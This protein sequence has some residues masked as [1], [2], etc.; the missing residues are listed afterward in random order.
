MSGAEYG[1]QIDDPREISMADQRAISGELLSAVV[2]LI[3]DAS[4]V[5]DTNGVIVSVNQHAEELFGYALGSLTGVTIE[6]LLPER[7]RSRH[8][9][10][11]S[12]F[13]VEARS[14][15]MGEG[16]E[17]TGRRRD[18]S[19]F[20][21]DISLAPIV[22]AG[23]QLVIAAVRDVTEQRK[24]NATSAELATIVRS[25]T[26]AIISTTLDGRITNWNP[27][28][29]TLLGYGTDQVLGLHISTLVPAHASPIL[30][31]L[32]DAAGQERYR[33][34]LL[35]KWLH[36]DGHE[37]DAS[38]SIS[39]LRDQTSTIL[40]FCYVIR[41]NTERKRAEDD[42]H[43][44]LEE[45]ERLQRQ[46]AMTSE[47]RLRLLSGASLDASLELICQRASEFVGAPA[48]AVTVKDDRGLHVVAGVGPVAAMTGTTLPPGTSFTEAVIQRGEALETP[49][50]SAGSRVEVPEDLP[51]GPMLG[52]PLVIA[53][54]AAGS[55]TFI[56][57][58]GAP[59]FDTHV[60]I[61]AE[62]LGAQAA[63][64]FELD[65]A[66][67]AREQMMLLGDRDRIAR[68]LHDHVIQQ[69][70]ATGLGLQSSL[71]WVKEDKARERISKS[72][73]VLDDTIREIR[74]TIF[75]LSQPVGG[76]QALRTQLTQFVDESSVVL[77]FAP[78]LEIIGLTDAGLPDPLVA[79]VLA[80]AREALSNVGRHAH[81]SAVLVQLLVDVDTVH[82]RVVDD[83]IGIGSPE[84]SSGLKNLH[85]RATMYHGALTLTNR[86]EGGTILEWTASLT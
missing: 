59:D 6:T 57:P 52:I 32:L 24:A 42:L 40:G 23:E 65:R 71:M 81:A 60:R 48:V 26:D 50:R 62:A 53:G 13:S 79:H 75:S 36:L 18:G 63:L 34:A 10:H 51:D 45:E 7:A 82:L 30:E 43:R 16:L 46:H 41:D 37:V 3:P 86:P 56:R 80:C 69:L 58:T 47:I 54:T 25:T 73:D 8:R 64:A 78:T 68:D 31:D 14:R 22:S 83:G 77:G 33:E 17:L 2:S 49:R 28:S 15:P 1:S 29:E 67:T 21:I 66:R 9:H 38:V 12:T 70:F 20:P 61:F 35:T 11:R 5:V 72:I 44:L 76:A 39:L 27:A 19:E 85:D 55:I 74:N 84:R 4:V